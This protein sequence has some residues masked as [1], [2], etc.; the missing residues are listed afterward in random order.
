MTN[1]EKQLFDNL[2]YHV[3]YL[4]CCGHFVNI[5]I[6]KDGFHDENEIAHLCIECFYCKI[7]AVAELDKGKNPWYSVWKRFREK[8]GVVA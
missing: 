4:T 5:S 1:K 8:S 3:K 6:I 7:I 2:P